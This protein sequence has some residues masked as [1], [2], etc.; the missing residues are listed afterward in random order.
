MIGIHA[1]KTR[2][3][4]EPVYS[5]GKVGSIYIPDAYQD[6]RPYFGDVLSAGS[7]SGYSTGERVV[8]RPIVGH[9]FYRDGRS[10][11]CIDRS[12]CVGRI[13]GKVFFPQPE[14]VVIK[15][16]WQQKYQQPSQL[17]YI[18]PSALEQNQPCYAGIICQV[19]KDCKDLKVGDYVL[20]PYTGTELGL[21]DTIF[22]ILPEKEILATVH[23]DRNPT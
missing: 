8:L 1:L 5:G 16:D 7:E 9:P 21:V 22:Y 17:I 3:I 12:D 20:Y 19:G 23:A 10:V 11:Y 2:L 15:P 6:S 13:E 18:P 14:D 4:V